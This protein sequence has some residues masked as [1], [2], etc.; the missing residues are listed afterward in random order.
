MLSV[1]TQG[2]FSDFNFLNK[3][4]LTSNYRFI[5]PNIIYDRIWYKFKEEKL[6]SYYNF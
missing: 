5:A 2:T 1:L 4:L 3:L 6:N